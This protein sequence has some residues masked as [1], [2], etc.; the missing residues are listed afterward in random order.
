MTRVGG[1]LRISEDDQGDRAGVNRQREDVQAMA[2]VRG[3]EVV[4][5]E[6]NDISAYKRGV[7]RPAFER[8]LR[9][10]KAG[11]IRGVLAW[12]IDRLARRPADLERLIDIYEASPHRLVFETQS[13]SYDLSTADGRFMARLFVNVA[14]KSSADT[15]RR[16]KRKH[17]EN[18]RKGKNPPGEA[19]FGWDPDDKSKLYPPESVPLRR[20]IEDSFRGKRDTTIAREW[21]EQGVISRKTGKPFAYFNVGRLLVRPRNAGIV[22]YQGKPLRGENGQYVMGEWEPVMTV[23][24]WEALCAIREN[25]RK[26]LNPDR[27]TKYLLSGILRC[28]ICGHKLRGQKRNGNYGYICVA[29]APGKCGKVGVAGPQADQL[30]REL[31]WIDAE[32]AIRGIRQAP[33]PWPKQAQLD[34]V[35]Q[36]IASLRERWANGQLSDETFIFMVE[37]LEQD[38]DALRHERAVY[39]AKAQGVGSRE[40]NLRE[41]WGDLSLEQQRLIINQSLV[42]VIVEPSG[43]GKRFNPDRLK[44]IFRT[45]FSE[46]F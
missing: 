40:I 16:I 10:L 23:E 24:E 13:Q 14:N 20:A 31:V 8:M 42:A 4:W 29:N 37:K 43:R 15:S 34:E 21:E 17:L 27:A 3:W 7:K 35:E 9:D 45:E 1:Y 26:G 28:G 41:Q 36:K 11:V 22:V 25:K 6:D 30:V 18:A 19:P 5:Y 12:D 39:N 32:R 33:K 46:R 2:D 38:R 44:P